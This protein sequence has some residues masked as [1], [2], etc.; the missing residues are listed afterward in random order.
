MFHSALYHIYKYIFI[1]FIYIIKLTFEEI[2]SSKLQ[3]FKK[4]NILKMNIL[5]FTKSISCNGGVEK[6][7][8]WHCKWLLKKKYK[9][10]II[11]LNSIGAD[12]FTS[13]KYPFI[14]KC[15]CKLV[16]SFFNL[17]FGLMQLKELFIQFKRNSKVIIYLPFL[18]GLISLS[19]IL[20]LYKIFRIK[21]PKIIFYHA[22]IPSN[23]FIARNVYLLFSWIIFKIHP[24]TKLISHS[25][26]EDNKYFADF[27]NKKIYINAI[28]APKIDK[29]FYKYK[30]IEKDEFKKRS[31][32]SFLGNKYL[33]N[34]F[35]SVYVG[36]LSKYKGLL[37]LVDSVQFLK[38]NIT[39]IIAGEGP[40]SN[41]IAKRIK[42]YPELIQRKIIFLPRFLKESEKFD[43]MYR[44]DMF[45]FPSINKGEAYGIA[46]LEALR[47]GIPIINYHL[48][49]GVN[50]I[51]QNNKQ[52]YTSFKN[53]PQEL[54]KNIDKM[55]HSIKDKKESF[56]PI[57][58]R[59]YVINNFSEDKIYSEFIQIFD[60]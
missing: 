32:P 12:K 48:G 50:S 5:I 46:Q 43:L 21:I 39:I 30:F 6:V 2:S 18:N 1:G 53:K 45:L 52:S 10:F 42:N 34:G 8:E 28:P 14:S 13:I 27:L 49:T 25:K 24:K 58:L 16:P 9:V 19:V 4:I 22:A 51:V 11:A 17:S 15:R 60:L 26:S 54:A 47:I 35:L 33:L 44:A 36:R 57:N 40:E 56:S 3:S 23:N 37:K 55:C 59:N 31:L 38:S 7:V 41:K 20:F 29:R